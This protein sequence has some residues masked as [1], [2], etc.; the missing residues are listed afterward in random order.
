MKK[1]RVVKQVPFF[2]HCFDKNRLKKWISHLYYETICTEDLTILNFVEALKTIGFKEATRA[3]VSIG[4]DDLQIP[5]N[6]ASLLKEIEYEVQYTTHAFALNRLTALENFQ[7]FIDIWHRTSELIKMEVVANFEQTDVL[8][9]VYMMAFSGAR[10]N[11]SQ[12]S[13]L[14]GMRGFMSDPEGQII[15][16]PIRSNFRE[17]LTLTEY[18]ISCYGARKGL[19]DTALRT[20]D[21]GY[22]TRRLVD[23]AHSI[24][25]TRF[26]CKTTQGIWLSAIKE[27]NQIVYPLEKR[28]MGRVLAENIYFPYIEPETK[29]NKIVQW[30]YLKKNQQIDAVK[31]KLLAKC[32][33][34]VLV[35][36][37][38]RCLKKKRLCQLC[39]GWTLPHAY[40]APIGEAVGI[41][42]AQSIGEP[43]TQ[44]TM[45][46]FHTGGVFS[47][48]L[49]EELKAPY[50]GKIQYKQSIQGALFRSSNGQLA[51]RTSQPGF[52][53]LEPLTNDKPVEILKLNFP[54]TSIL[55]IK[56]DEKIR[57][58]EVLIEL[59]KDQDVGKE[60]V[61]NT[62]TYYSKRSGIIQVYKTHLFPFEN[63]NLVSHP[64]LPKLEPFYEKAQSINRT[65][66]SFRIYCGQIFKTF[67]LNQILA[68]SGDLVNTK[69]IINRTKLYFPT[70]IK[71]T[72]LTMKNHNL[73]QQNQLSNVVT[74]TS[75]LNLSLSNLTYRKQFG[76]ISYLQQPQLKKSLQIIIP[77]LKQNLI[78][79]KIKSGI[80]VNDFQSSVGG[81]FIYPLIF[82]K[83][84]CSKPQSNCEQQFYLNQ[85]Q[86]KSRSRIKFKSLTRLI[87]ST[88]KTI[89]LTQICFYI[90]EPKYQIL[91]TILKRQNRHSIT[92]FRKTQV[93]GRVLSNHKGSTKLSKTMSLNQ[94]QWKMQ[95]AIIAEKVNLQQTS[96]LGK[97]Q[98]DGFIIKK[99]LKTQNLV[100][101]HKK[102][103][104]SIY[105]Q[106]KTRYFFKTG[107]PVHS[108]LNRMNNHLQNQFHYFGQ[109]ILTDIYFLTNCKFTEYILQHY[110]STFIWHKFLSK[111]IILRKSIA[112]FEIQKLTFPILLIRSNTEY[113]FTGIKTTSTLNIYK[114]QFYKDFQFNQFKQ[115]QNLTSKTKY[116]IEKLQ[117]IFLALNKKGKTNSKASILDQQRSSLKIQIFFRNFLRTPCLHDQT[118]SYKSTK[119]YEEHF[120]QNKTLSHLYF[121]LSPNSLF[122]KQGQIFNGKQI[123][124]RKYSYGYISSINQQNFFKNCS[125]SIYFYQSKHSFSKPHIESHIFCPYTGELS[126]NIRN[127]GDDISSLVIT[128]ND[129]YTIAINAVKRNG[130]IGDYIYSG[131]PITAI[132]TVQYTGQIIQIQ[133][134]HIK[135]QLIENSLVASNSRFFC[136]NKQFIEK[137]SQIFTQSYPRLQMGDIVQGI[138]KIEEFF[139]ARQTKDGNPFDNNLHNRLKRRFKYYIKNCRYPLFIAARK[140]IYDIQ[141]LIIDSIFK[142]YSSQ[143]IDISDKHLEIIVRQ[144]TSKVKVTQFWK[145]GTPFVPFK[146]P[147]PTELYSRHYIERYQYRKKNTRVYNVRYEPAILGITRAAL[148]NDGF[149]S[150][151]SFQE[152]T[153]ILSRGAIFQKKDYL[154]GLKENVILGHIIPAGTAVRTYSRRFQPVI[155][156]QILGKQTLQILTIN[157]QCRLELVD[158]INVSSQYL[159]PIRH[160]ILQCICLEYLKII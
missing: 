152:T 105:W 107:W 37:P 57:K 77:S 128:N 36:S 121:S 75:V 97:I 100:K 58:G 5:P 2:D 125:N 139:E 56:N 111:K 31:A 159:N 103:N 123:F 91:D 74:E 38:L 67:Q 157:H 20:A 48:A 85:L 102:P 27:N 11:L 130:Q 81:K 137:T 68:Q 138:P 158:S 4:I 148:E 133:K 52:L 80:K 50:S 62:Y 126:L 112:T 43:G 1:K 18:V 143:G 156:E 117:E 129:T 26:D 35:R 86:N 160:N 150:A 16:Y 99:G 64:K 89:D 13:Q 49:S 153:R 7:S 71:L 69:S 127:N 46:T 135:I 53:V 88:K 118:D 63:Y 60:T 101:N 39:Y 87:K 59:P 145:Y 114:K 122:N 10:G 33:T 96:K 44:L 93:Y 120:Y 70:K 17:G 92:K 30:S 146:H 136:K 6:K 34:R 149:I 54:A 41:L 154:K 140:S 84:N 78:S 141:N 151:A 40:L 131:L 19:V 47:G 110:S 79:K 132:Q 32:F 23:V 144:M 9:P 106:V 124:D 115:I 55:F 134:D 113:S 116:K 104:S 28:I 45:R 25:I 21:A 42:A 73:T 22:L 29:K 95:N 12:V 109:M 14:V 24:I 76:Y 66:H 142:L 51:F 82:S 15:D 90:S 98:K 83:L 108:S 155:M 147:L 72:F 65:F 8:N 119:L 61:L 3:G 94:F